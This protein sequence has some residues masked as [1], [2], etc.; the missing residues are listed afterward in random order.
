[1]AKGFVVLAAVAGGLAVLLAGCTGLQQQT[2]RGL[3]TD[4]ADIRPAARAD[5]GQV[6]LGG[7]VPIGLSASEESVIAA[8]AAGQQ[9]GP[10]MVQWTGGILSESTD[11]LKQ[12]VSKVSEALSPARS[13]AR[14]DDSLQLS[15]KAKPTP[16]LYLAMAR[17]YEQSGKLDQAD[18]T[19]RQALQ[20][21]PKDLGVALN[22]AR[23]KDRQGLWQEALQAYQQTARLHP[24][25]AALWNDVGLLLARQGKNQDA[26]EAFGRAVRLQPKRALYRNNLAALLVDM[27]QPE[28][29]MAQLRAVYA[30]AEASYKL[31]YLLQK[32][33]RLSDA[34][35]WFAR[36]LQFNPSMNEARIWLRY[37][38]ERLGPAAQM[39]RGKIVDAPGAQGP[40][41][42]GRSAPGPL[43]P[44][45]PEPVGG[46][47]GPRS[48]SSGPGASAV[49]PLPPVVSR[50][51][52]PDKQGGAHPPESAVPEQPPLPEGAGPGSRVAEPP[53]L[54]GLPDAPLPEEAAPLPL[55][56]VDQ[57][58]TSDEPA[59]L[60][61][62]DY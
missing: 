4:G 24:N 48:G 11:T 15:T 44:R 20:L 32:K 57:Q 7:A 51:P 59:P 35:A 10:P 43:G 2:P 27:G 45:P 46:R 34:A 21:W 56:A 14:T 40:G 39:A 54:E 5:Q 36:A 12:G 6:A 18:R 31:G 37:L 61:P 47:A 25:E 30:Q 33:G 50:L 52:E 55:P 49:R 41:N 22:Y 3:P 62:V 26:R 38:E 53:G 60:P 8:V 17:F 42:P 16:A 1:M 9:G 19:Y 23:F 58:D 28:E 13:P 29:A